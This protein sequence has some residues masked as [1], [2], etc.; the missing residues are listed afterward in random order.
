MRS[1]RIDRLVECSLPNDAARLAIFKV[2]SKTLAL[3]ETVDF[4]YF[5]SKT[6]N[7]TGADIQS[8]LTSA[9][10]IAIKEALG[11]CNKVR[12]FFNF[13]TCARL[14]N[15]CHITYNVKQML[16]IVYSPKTNL[17]VGIVRSKLF[18]NL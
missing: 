9:N 6:Q 3:D 7:Y 4:E 12:T 15:I 5:A 14:Q 2:L 1:G 18:L 16:G 11:Q 10:M 13:S 17:W 8:I